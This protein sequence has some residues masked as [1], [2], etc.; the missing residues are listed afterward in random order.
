MSYRDLKRVEYHRGD[1]GCWVLYL[2][3]QEKTEFDISHCSSVLF[4]SFCVCLVSLNFLPFVLDL[5]YLLFL[6]SL[7]F[8]LYS[9]QLSRLFASS[10]SIFLHISFSPAFSA[11]FFLFFYSYCLFSFL[12]YFSHSLS[13]FL[14]S[15]LPL[16]PFS[17]KLLSSSI[18]TRPKTML[19]TTGFQLVVMI[20]L[21]VVVMGKPTLFFL[22]VSL[23]I[24]VMEACAG[25]EE[26]G[27]YA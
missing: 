27:I 25:T 6:C 15:F 10:F 17:S 5:N 9:L 14:M 23:R 2:S 21:V 26:E 11:S 4:W 13:F 7:S 19:A 16:V 22:Y 8:L 3:A 1:A 12:L 18:F 24:I 20:I